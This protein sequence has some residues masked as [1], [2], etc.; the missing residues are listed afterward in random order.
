MLFVEMRRI[1]PD[2]YTIFAGARYGFIK[3]DKPPTG[4]PAPPRCVARE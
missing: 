3:H 2:L 1:F 4:R